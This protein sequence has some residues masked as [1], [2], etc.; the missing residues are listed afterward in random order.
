MSQ[1]ISELKVGAASGGPTERFLSFRGDLSNRD[2][3]EAMRVEAERK[4]REKDERL[5]IWDAEECLDSS[6][7]DLEECVEARAKG[8][9]KG[10]KMRTMQADMEDLPDDVDWYI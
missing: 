8:A 2:L 4:E 9:K 10:K 3:E 1:E 7:K 6:V 5:S